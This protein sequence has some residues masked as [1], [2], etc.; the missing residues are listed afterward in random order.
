[1]K[2]SMAVSLRGLCQEQS[3]LALAG[4]TTFARGCAYATRG[5]VLKLQ[6]A[7]QTVSAEVQ[8]GKL[9]EVRLWKRREQLQFSC[10]CPS[11]QEGAFCKHCVAVARVYAQTLDG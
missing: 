8:G 9:Y 10:N 5:C 2:D 3:L 6:G 11:A 7:E 4:A 1:M